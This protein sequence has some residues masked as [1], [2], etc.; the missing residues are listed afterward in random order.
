M[1]FLKSLFNGEALTF[2]Q[3][4][5]KVKGAKFTVANIADGSYVSRAKFEDETG[6]LK[7]QV[8]DL[9]KQIGK[10][11][12]DMKDLQSKLTAAQGD[13]SKLAE[14]QKALSDLQAQY[15]QTQKDY[16]EKLAAQSYEFAVRS[17]AAK[18]KFTSTA[19]Q[20]DFIR[21]AI[22]KKMQMEKDTI[23]GF[24]DYV[25]AYKKDDPG[26]FVAEKSEG[27]NSTDGND[28]AGAKSNPQIVLPSGG[29]PADPDKNAFKFHFNGVR[30]RPDEKS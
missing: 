3:L 22:E 29:N 10:R 14:A 11:D 27:G 28:G 1:D 16:D 23:L 8:D 13:Q 17:E 6:K 2:E 15:A 24:N 20:R 30:P 26:A 21:N 12:T 18:L 19:A 5:E 4:V 25:E 9:Q 7:T